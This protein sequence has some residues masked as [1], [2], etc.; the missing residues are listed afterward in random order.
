MKISQIMKHI[1]AFA[2]LGLALN[3]DNVGL[4]I[5]DKDWDVSSVLVSLDVTPIAVERA[6][7]SGCQLILS[8]HPLI[9]RPIKSIVH[10]LHIRLIQHQIAVISLHTNL[11]VAR[12][13]V[14][15]ALAERLGLQVLES[16]S[17]ET[18][19][20]NH[21]IVVDCSP[22]AV[23]RVCEA[24]WQ[25]G[26]GTIGNYY[27]CGTRHGVQANFSPGAK[28][29]PYAT[30]DNGSTK[31]EMALE[32]MCDSFCLQI[33]LAAIIRVHPYETPALY[34]F[35]VDSPNPAYGLGLVCKDTEAGS[36]A[37]L[38]ERVKTRLNCPQLKL[39]TAGL[40]GKTPIGR[41]AVCGGSG[42]SLLAAAEAKAQLYISGDIGYH[43]FLD[44]RIPIIDAG[45]FYTE[46]PALDLLKGKMQELGISSL[47]LAQQEHEYFRNMQ[48]I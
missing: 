7:S 24:A 42:A 2:P 31:A 5:G 41:I 14:N 26:A 10:P 47:I 40:E 16:L 21:H 18:G 23:D 12:Q 37:E 4:Q 43:N 45:H 15:H 48:F 13:S 20:K 44:S 36:L 8:H 22:E 38:A 9:F 39:W 1:E 33:V 35:P 46:Y 29:N 25:A 28:A 11:D 34:H 32:F 3:W 27:R 6:I 19:A 30:V 17:S